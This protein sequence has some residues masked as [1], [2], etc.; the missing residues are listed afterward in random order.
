MS[1]LFCLQT[2]G[3]YYFLGS[4]LL[5]LY[6]PSNFINMKKALFILTFTLQALL[7]TAQC[8]DT[9]NF[10]NYQPPCNPDLVPVCGC[11]GVTYTNNCF[12]DF[13]TVTQY[14]DG[15]CEQVVMR[16]SPNPATYWL[17]VTI[18]TKYEADVSLYIFDRTGNIYYYQYLRAVNSQILNIPL[19][20]FD[21]GLYIVMVESNGVSQL[22]KIIKWEQ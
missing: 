10:P 14:I 5:R 19:N 17:D 6:E 16:V 13:A 21:Q 4:Y 7:S 22:S 12:A 20:G 9:L 3:W 18:V 2:M 1:G 15:P 11:D 8:L